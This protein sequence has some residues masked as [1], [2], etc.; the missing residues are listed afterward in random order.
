M[1]RCSAACTLARARQNPGSRVRCPLVAPCWSVPHV[2][3]PLISGG[4]V[5]VEEV[6]ELEL[7]DLGLVGGA[8]LGGVLLGL[9]RV[10]SSWPEAR[11]MAKGRL[12]WPERLGPSPVGF[13]FP[14]YRRSCPKAARPR[15]RST[16]M[17]ETRTFTETERGFYPHSKLT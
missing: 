6:F 17:L 9:P 5:D 1:P 4:L 16:D 3:Y 7:D 10:C 15:M 12:R 8:V 2:V 14:T 13:L 11:A